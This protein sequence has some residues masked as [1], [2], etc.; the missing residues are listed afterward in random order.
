MAEELPGFR[1]EQSADMQWRVVDDGACEV[2]SATAWVRPDR[3]CILS[4]ADGENVGTPLLVE[5]AA[6]AVSH[7]LLVNVRAGD[8]RLRDRYAALGFEE[9]RTE[10]VYTI[11]VADAVAR[12]DG[13]K[14]PAELGVRTLPEVPEDELRELDDRLRRD[15]PG[16]DGWT[17][18]AAG[19]REETY[20]PWFI[21]DLYLVAVDIGTRAPVGI[22]RVST[23]EGRLSRLAFI[24]TVPRHRR[25]GVA[26]GLLSMIFARLHDRGAEFITTEADLENVGSTTLL[27]SIGARR[28]GGYV[29]L[30]LAPRPEERGD[31]EASERR[32]S[33]R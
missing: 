12:L 15:V 5:A 28:V 17:W 4:L 25:T 6:N 14:L 20:G 11:R 33:N 32:G 19:F 16:T 2:A 23:R 18:S 3:R 22:A 31:S 30:S 1:V 26:R 7:E 8:H 9:K 27:M 29:E 13:A 21:P 10:A 24:G